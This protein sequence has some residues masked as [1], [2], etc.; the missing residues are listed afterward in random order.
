MNNEKDYDIVQRIND[1]NAK[2][3]TV[4]DNL[5]WHD[6]IDNSQDPNQDDIIPLSKIDS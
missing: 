3:D 2:M 6:D 1:L 4:D 5:T